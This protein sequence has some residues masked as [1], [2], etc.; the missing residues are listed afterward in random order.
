MNG[1]DVARSLQRIDRRPV[2]LR[3]DAVP[4]CVVVRNEVGRV[5]P[6]LAHHRAIGVGP[7]LVVDNGSTDGTVEYLLDQPDVHLWRTDV[8]FRVGNY[9]AAFFEVLLHEHGR[10]HWVVIVDADECFVFPGSEHRSVGELCA[11]L[12]AEQVRAY[13]AVLL[14]LYADA[15]LAD[16]V[17]PSDRSP[18]DVAHYFDRRWRH[19]EAA[20][21]GPY[22]NQVGV[23]GGVRRRLFG[24]TAWDYC[25]SK[26]PL[27]RFEA[28]VTLVGGQHWSPLPQ[29]G[30]RGAVLHH[31]LDHRLAAFAWDELSRGQRR[32]HDAEYH[33]YAEALALA[34]QLSAFDPAESIRYEGTEQLG[35]LG[36]IG[37]VTD[38]D[39]GIARAE[40]LATHA[41]DRVV[42]EP[43][44]AAALLARAAAVAPTSVT[45]LVR[46]AA[47]HRSTGDVV[48]A[49]AA[50]DEACARR[51]DDLEV[52]ALTV[53][54]PPV[55]PGWSRWV[56]TI[57]A[58]AMAGAG[59]GL[60]VD[61]A[62]DVTFG[63]AAPAAFPSGAGASWGGIVHGA[64]APIDHLPPFARFALP[65]LAERPAFVAALATCR[66]LVTFT[67][68]A[69]AALAGP[70]RRAGVEVVVVAPPVLIGADE[71]DPDRYAAAPA[72]VQPGW[73][74]TRLHTVCDLVV[75]GV[76]KVRSV[77]ARWRR[78][79]TAVGNAQRL[80]DGW[81]TDAAALRATTDLAVDPP[82][83][84]VP[85]ASPLPGRDEVDLGPAH[86]VVLADLIDANADPVVLA[87]LGRARPLLVPRLP[88]VVELLGADYPL[89][90]DDRAALAGLLADRARV[91]AAQQ[92]LAERRHRYT[93]ERFLAALT[94]CRAGWA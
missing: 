43:A 84:P 28:G 24:G 5:G 26:V 13:S 83:A 34:P 77:P 17:L 93:P 2:D 11:E 49:A 82:G 8:E 44:K 61:P 87:C 65:A 52:A 70:A 16:T 15:P 38:P 73:W 81:A 35:A 53:G 20:R 32:A 66:G 48:A 78:L 94:E 21:S 69:A 27:V 36:I 71:F 59:P 76:A 12:D 41:A 19:A 92:H 7:F 67:E 56:E 80:H 54:G 74:L 50:L 31:K 46:L 10:G 23:F 75:P 55:P 79:A 1:A 51:P 58:G 30:H 37:P 4:A 3:P 42:A 85:D 57:M 64:P 22:R 86:A 91:A 14:D 6:L 33:R 47:L 90:F 63:P 9:G 72:V 62:V 18:L 60:T 89:F 40:A 68:H 45:P 88:G 39:H 25:L 29:A